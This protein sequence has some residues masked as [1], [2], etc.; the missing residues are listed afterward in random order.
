MFPIPYSLY[1]ISWTLFPIFYSLF[2]V[3][4][5]WSP[6]ADSLLLIPYPLFP[7][8]FS[9]VLLSFSLFLNSHS[10]FSNYF[11][12]LPAPLPT[13]HIVEYLRLNTEFSTGAWCS[14]YSA[15]NFSVFYIF[16]VLYVCFYIFLSNVLILNKFYLQ[17]LCM[18]WRPRADCAAPE[19]GGWGG[20]DRIRSHQITSDHVRRHI[21]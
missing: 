16:S 21:V 9:L 7:I 15:V 13:F 17:V 12:L 18:C 19:N 5:P 14:P 6:T 20:E 3:P 2:H 8:P 10:S 4:Y 11:S 1:H